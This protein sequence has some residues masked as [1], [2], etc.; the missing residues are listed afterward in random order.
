MILAS[1]RRSIRVGAK[2]MLCN[3]MRFTRPTG[4]ADVCETHN[5]MK[6]SVQKFEQTRPLA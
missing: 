5:V 2:T 3:T 1:S 6:S 4:T